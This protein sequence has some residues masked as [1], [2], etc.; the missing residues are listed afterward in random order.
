MKKLIYILLLIPSLLA[1]QTNY[2]FSNSGDDVT[3]EGTIGNPWATITKVNTEMVNY[4]AGDSIL[5]ERGDTFYGNVHIET[6]GSVGSPVVF[7][8]Y[9]TGEKPILTALT[10]ITSWMAYTEADIYYQEAVVETSPE[11]VL[12]N[13]TQRAMGRWPNSN[14]YPS[15]QTWAHID[16]YTGGAGADYTIT[17]SDMDHSTVIN[18]IGAEA[19]VRNSNWN[20]ITRYSI[21]DHTVR[22]LTFPDPHA[23]YRVRTNW[24]YFIQ[25]H[26]ETLDAFSEWYHDDD[27]LYIHFGGENP[28]LQEVFVSTLDYIFSFVASSNYITIENLNLIGANRSAVYVNGCDY[29]TV[30]DCDVSY[31]GWY[32]LRGNDSDY[33]DFNNNLIEYANDCAIFLWEC[34]NAYIGYNTSEN[35]ALIQGMGLSPWHSGKAFYMAVSHNKVVEHNVILNSGF[36]G[37][38]FSGNNDTIRYNLVDMYGLIKEDCGGIQYGAQATYSDIV[39]DSNIVLNGVGWTSGTPPG[40]TA[41]Q[42]FGIY[43]DYNS[44]GGHTVSNNVVAHSGNS[45]LLISGSPNFTITGNLVYDHRL[46][47]L[48]FTQPM[49]TANIAPNATV[50][51]NIFI[52]K[53]ATNSWPLWASM[54]DAD[55]YNNMGSWD[56]NVYAR[57][58][59]R[60]SPIIAQVSWQSPSGFGILT[61]S[62][63]QTLI[64][65]EANSAIAPV[66]IA[67]TDELHFIYND[68]MEEKYWSLSATMVDAWNVSYSEMVTLQPFTGMVLIGAGEVITIPPPE[69]VILETG[70]LSTGEGVDL[71][72]LSK[73]G[74]PIKITIE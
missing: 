61:L 10:E 43:F 70:I 71:K 23:N 25:N 8:A 72:Y 27:T 6:A 28:A 36:S 33:L 16:S 63:W 62:D 11:I 44:S 45:G 73:D 48:S 40:T 55:F 3:G 50:T 67:S 42:V 46:R 53:Q 29:V 24:G 13:G 68:S 38:H 41:N 65:D 4:L 12:V 59:N 51:N 19:V 58:M 14:H 22:T 26:I 18:W 64:T 7:G 37:I 69:P 54:E 39:V 21:T 1:G 5:F 35:I 60:A 56:Y 57:P 9:G 31:I 20:K 66:D 15:A 47:V 34:D 2:Y 52:G 32:A 17:D 49:G 30:Q 74:A